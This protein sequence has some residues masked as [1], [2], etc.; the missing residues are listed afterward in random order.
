MSAL[1]QLGDKVYFGGKD[2][3]WIDLA[4]GEIDMKTIP[5]EVGQISEHDGLV[6]YMRD[7]SRS[8]GN[9]EGKQPTENGTEF[10]LIDLNDFTLKSAFTLWKSDTAV[11]GLTDDLSSE[12]T[13]RVRGPLD[14]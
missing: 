2:L 13:D 10:G 3:R 14:C 4:T 5:D 6:F 7:V 9:A 12:V 1:P 8:S 11:L